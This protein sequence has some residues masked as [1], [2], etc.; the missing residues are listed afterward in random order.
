MTTLA[1]F[2]AAALAFGVTALTARRLIPWMQRRKLTR[3]PVRRREGEYITGQPAPVM[4]FLP[5]AA[6][7]V[8]GVLPALVLLA[9]DTE[10]PGLLATEVS[11]LAGGALLAL[12]LGAVGLMDDYRHTRS[13]P[14]F[15]ALFLT[16]AAGA[17][18]LCYLAALIL[19]GDYSTILIL[20]WLGQ[21][22]LGI[23]YHPLC[24][25]LTVGM[26]MG[27][28]QLDAADGAAPTASLTAGL[29]LG[30]AGGML[31][32]SSAGVLGCALGGLSLA[33][34]LYCLPPVKL[35]C[36][37]GGSMLLGGGVMA[38]AMAC[39]APAFLLPAALPWLAE[40]IYALVRSCRLALTGR[41]MA[42]SLGV[43]LLERGWSDR[44]VACF[45]MILSLLGLALTIL[46][47]GG[48]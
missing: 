24:L 2:L 5:L 13:L 1:S 26:T 27:S 14:G 6:G 16:L 23:W 47:A 29:A 37:R 42:P 34:L 19:S 21:V 36:G 4:G 35:R 15:S 31:G 11:R 17:V 7:L 48:I 25:L 12:G 18:G 10:T 3:A 45:W 22:D 41:E 32:S 44:W 8:A 30:L 38:A 46:A 28:S 20:P 33:I 9:V 40:G 43:W 39:G